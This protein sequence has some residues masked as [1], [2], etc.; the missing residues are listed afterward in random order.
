MGIRQ[1]IELFH[2]LFCKSLLTTQDKSLFVL[3]GGCNLRFFLGSD[4]YSEDIDFDIE[5]IARDTLHKRVDKVLGG[6]ALVKSLAARKIEITSHSAPKQTDTVQRWKIR[7]RAQG[8]EV[9]SKIEFSRRG[10]DYNGVQFAPIDPLVSASHSLSPTF[11]SHYG[12]EHAVIQK[13]EA[14]AGRSETQ[15][16]DIYDLA[17][18][19]SRHPSTKPNMSA[20]IVSTAVNCALSIDFDQFRGQVVEY[21]EGDSR[22]FY[23]Q[24][25]AWDEL[26]LRVVSFLEG[27]QRDPK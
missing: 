16:R 11:M 26:Q 12:A 7:L 17:L 15:A 5:T 14:L 1:E 24:Q 6:Q 23:A 18:L 3:K 9:P 22:A 8:I 20:S 10:I 4:R 27:I 13:I 19:C 21:L 25:K 2:L